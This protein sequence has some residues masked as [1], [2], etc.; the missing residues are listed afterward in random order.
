MVIETV[1]CIHLD[2]N[3]FIT[4]SDIYEGFQ[5][6]V[7]GQQVFVEKMNLNCVAWL[8]SGQTLLIKKIFMVILKIFKLWP[9]FM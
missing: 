8:M 9:R 3:F 2:H 6:Q 5:I 7:S 4:F 1:L